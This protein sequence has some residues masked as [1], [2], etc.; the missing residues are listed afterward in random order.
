M[1]CCE[2]ATLMQLNDG[3]KQNRIGHTSMPTLEKL[4]R[5]RSRSFS[6]ARLFAKQ[7]DIVAKRRV[8]A[9]EAEEGQIGKV[10]VYFRGSRMLCAC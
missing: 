2:P 7:F 3:P 10:N 6:R 4:G 8:V 1:H 9:A 5:P